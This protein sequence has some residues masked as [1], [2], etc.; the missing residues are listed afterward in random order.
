MRDA[1]KREDTSVERETGLELS[2][3]TTVGQVGYYPQAPSPGGS[4]LC[5][6]PCDAQRKCGP[7]V[8]PKLVC[9]YMPKADR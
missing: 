6:I 1:N 5:S 7:Q 8:V 3:C 2:A 9:V 4:D